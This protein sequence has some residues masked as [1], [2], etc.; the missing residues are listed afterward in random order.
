[1]TELELVRAALDLGAHEVGAALSAGERAW[2]SRAAK[3]PRT[4]ARTLR[5]VRD[6]VRAGGD[7]LGE[8]FCATRTGA[9]RRTTG[10]FYTP[11][12]IVEPMVR[13]LLERG[14]DRVVDAGCGSGRFTQAVLRADRNLATICVDRDPVATLMMRA[15]LRVLGAQHATVVSADYTRCRISRIAGRTGFIGNPPYVR[16][17][18]LSRAAKER[19]ALLAQRLGHRFSKLA[20][21]HAHFFL[22][23]ACHARAGD[24]G[25]FVTSAEWLDVG[26]G[27]IVRELLLNGLGGSCVHAIV[28][29]ACPFDDAMTTAAVTCFEV[30]TKPEHL[31]FSVSQTAS[32][33]KDLGARGALVPRTVLLSSRR[34]TPLLRGNSAGDLGAPLGSIVRVSRGQ[35]TGANAFF[36]MSAERAKELGVERWCKPAIASALEVL[37]CGGT[38]RNHAARMLVLDPPAD[39][40]RSRHPALDRYL[41][42]GERRTG[43]TPAICDR[44]V[45]RARSPWWAVRASAPPIVATYM[46]RQ[47][48]FFALNPDALVTLNVVHGLWPREPM[49]DDALRALVES[50]NRRRAS[51]VGR[52]RT[53]HGGLEK[54]EPREMEAL[55]LSLP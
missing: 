29:K 51:F 7:P 16:H 46:A 3:S 35:V 30:G 55:P 24:F 20:G 25:C 36:V 42:T 17:H 33:S 45:A 28:P 41:R 43:S 11:K 38:I 32:L 34:W 49:N 15:A 14:P 5:R 23:T 50:L 52:G 26:Y 12:T 37:S 54:F 39:I 44:Y 9:Q 19:A 40:D 48:P 4:P 13:W 31:V 53:Y 27:S 10:S 21:L 8:I 1:M 6:D 22:A 18:A 2:L 47:A